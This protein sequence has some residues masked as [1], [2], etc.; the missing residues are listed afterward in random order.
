MKL[1]IRIVM[2][3]N[4]MNKLVMVY[5]INNKLTHLSVGTINL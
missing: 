1:V 3:Y 5:F 4:L 2:N